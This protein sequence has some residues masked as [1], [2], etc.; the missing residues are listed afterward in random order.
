MDISRLNKKVTFRYEKE[1]KLIIV[2]MILH[3]WM[4]YLYDLTCMIESGFWI[5]VA[6]I[7]IH[8]VIILPP[9]MVYK[10]TGLHREE[11]NF[12]NKS[13]YIYGILAT[14][15]FFCA[16]QIVFGLEFK[17]DGYLMMPGNKLWLFIY[18][19]FVIAISEEFFFRVYLLEELAVIFGRFKWLAPIISGVFFGMIH[20]INM[21]L[22]SVYMN[23]MIGI[24][25]GYAKLYIKNC[26]F[27]SC[28]MAH[29]LYDFIITVTGW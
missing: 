26:T 28:V 4:T 21:G 6:D 9:F 16:C 20:W 8:L 12:K 23:I 3:Y 17:K 11:I 15:I 14:L 10:K 25:L 29:G 22:D 2:M 1:I 24:A 19:F 13:Q 27:I 18:F 7:V 5:D